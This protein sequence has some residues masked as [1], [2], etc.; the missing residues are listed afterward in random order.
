MVCLSS[1]MKQRGGLVWFNLSQVSGS[2]AASAARLLL[3]PRTL[4]QHGDRFVCLCLLLPCFG[5]FDYLM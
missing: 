2:P 1:E 3:L 5:S 4:G